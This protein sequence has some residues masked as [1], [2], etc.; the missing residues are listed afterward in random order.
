MFENVAGILQTDG[1][2]FVREI[3][4]RRGKA[5]YRTSIGLLDAA[6]VGVP[7]RRTR[8]FL[9]AAR[10]RTPPDVVA[11]TDTAPITVMDAPSA[12]C[13]YFATVTPNLSCLIDARRSP[14]TPPPSGQA[15]KDAT[16]IW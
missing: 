15:P 8:F 5:G 11:S 12:T 13:P 16:G 6:D 1:N 2:F 3:E 14:P 10:N 7:Q 9:V 4:T